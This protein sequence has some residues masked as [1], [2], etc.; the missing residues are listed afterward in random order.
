MSFLENLPAESFL[1][2]SQ[3]QQETI[4]GGGVNYTEINQETYESSEHQVDKQTEPTTGKK[5]PYSAYKPPVIFLKK[6]MFGLCI[7]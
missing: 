6:P 4:A 2:L 3:E 1:E 7:F 5:E